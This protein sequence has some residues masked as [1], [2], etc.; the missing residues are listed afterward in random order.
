MKQNT[1]TVPTQRRL[2]VSV[3]MA[4]TSHIIDRRRSLRKIES[5]ERDVWRDRR[6]RKLTR[7]Y[8]C[9]RSVCVCVCA[10]ALGNEMLSREWRKTPRRQR[11]DSCGLPDINFAVIYF[12]LCMD[13]LTS[14]PPR[15][16]N[17]I[18]CIQRNM[19][20]YAVYIC[21]WTND[22]TW[23][24]PFWIQL[25]RFYRLPVHITLLLSIFDDDSIIII[26][27]VGNI[28]GI[29]LRQRCDIICRRITK[30]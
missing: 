27:C 15:T 9:I 12:W 3:E 16:R 14:R 5:Y 18:W 8:D 11:R 26:R 30:K 21:N 1:V 10:S 19:L 2:T 4:L 6:Q 7:T 25:N 22:I 13:V 24:V 28:D 29:W 23:D 17:R 20:L